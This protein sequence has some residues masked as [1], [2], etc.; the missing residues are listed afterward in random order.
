MGDQNGGRQKRLMI[1]K[2]E[3][4]RVVDSR[5]QR[6]KKV[7]KI[8]RTTSRVLRQAVAPCRSTRRRRGVS[9]PPAT[10]EMTIVPRAVYMFISIMFS[11][12]FPTLFPSYP[13][14]VLTWIYGYKEEYSV[15]LVPVYRLIVKRGRSGSRNLTV[16]GLPPRNLV[17]GQNLFGLMSLAL[18]VA[19]ACQLSIFPVP[20]VYHA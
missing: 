8:P 19:L 14:F 9:L 15:F 5:P 7:R 4:A 17:I 11:L 10:P 1:L 2:E 18:F 20:F 13:F 6:G 16:E 3:V 12:Y